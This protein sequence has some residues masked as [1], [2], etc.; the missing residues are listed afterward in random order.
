M[1]TNK[2]EDKYEQASQQAQAKFEAIKEMVEALQKASEPVHIDSEYETAIQAIHEDALSVEIRGDWIAVDNYDCAHK[3]LA[4]PVEY[5]ILL[6][7]GGPAVRITGRLGENCQPVTTRLEMQDW[8]IPW[9]E[10]RPINCDDTTFVSRIDTKAEEILLRYAEC[11][12]Y[13]E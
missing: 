6:C 10:Y 9:Q 4:K 7:T 11:F 8:F 2:Q 13:G 5:R 12:Y 1:T 3:D